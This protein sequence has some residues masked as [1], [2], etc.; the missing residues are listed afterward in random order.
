MHSLPNG[1]FIHLIKY[2]LS[3]IWKSSAILKMLEDGKMKL[4]D[5]KFKTHF[6]PRI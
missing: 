4:E 6:L 1:N 3:V 2:L 5:I